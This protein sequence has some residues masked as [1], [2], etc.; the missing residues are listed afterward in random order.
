MEITGR[1][2]FRINLI[3]YLYRCKKWQIRQLIMQDERD[4]WRKATAGDEDSFGRL[5]EGNYT[6]LLRYGV[7]FGHATFLV[8]EAIQE[9]FI[10]IWQHRDTLS[11]PVA[12]K[13]YLF[14]ALRNILLNK[15][16]SRKKEVPIG[17]LEDFLE[18]ELSY[19]PHE[20]LR[21]ELSEDM[22]RMLSQLTPRQKE[23]IYLYFFEDLSY[24]EIADLM[25]LAVGGTYKLVYRA[26]DQ[27][28]ALAKT[29]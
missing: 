18:F 9:L 8:E 2:L 16:A 24:A 11:Q 27:L 29:V 14:K 22:Q 5:F 26:L 4:L 28:R 13:P 19:D 21:G 17:A 23:A 1:L 15:I 6:P 10:K 12:V 7:R 3:R 20:N 25:H